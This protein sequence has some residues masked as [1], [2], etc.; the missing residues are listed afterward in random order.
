M[1]GFEGQDGFHRLQSRGEQILM[2]DPSEEHVL[3]P[4]GAPGRLGKK[5]SP[6]SGV[7]MND[8]VRSEAKQNPFAADLGCRRR[9]HRTD[10][11]CG[12]SGSEGTDLTR[13]VAHDG[14]A[15]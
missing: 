9:G 13:A 10:G 14:D 15:S 12:Q 8:G 2:Q 1:G 5:P 3:E 7:H 4:Q 6:P 11:Q